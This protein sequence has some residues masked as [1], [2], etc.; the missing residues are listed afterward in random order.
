MKL[1]F[2]IFF[3]L[4]IL[5]LIG[6]GIFLFMFDLDKYRGQITS[7]LSHALDRPVTIDKMAMKI[8]MIP[9]IKISGITVG[10]PKNSAIKEPLAKINAVELT[11]ELS[12]LLNKEVKIKDVLIHDTVLNMIL[13][14]SEAGSEKKTGKKT[15]S[16]QKASQ[17]INIPTNNPY[18]SQL[19]VDKITLD[20]ILLNYQKGNTKEQIEFQ[21]MT[22]RQLKAVSMDIQYH[23]VPA[24]LNIYT[25]LMDLIKMKNNFIFNAD[26]S[27]LD[28]MVRVSGN[29]GNLKKLENILLN[30]NFS[31]ENFTSFLTKAATALQIPLSPLQ[32]QIPNTTLSASVKGNLDQFNIQSL[33]LSLGEGIIIDLKGRLA[34]LASQAEGAL[35]GTVSVR[36][37]QFVSLI[38]L[39]PMTINWKATLKDKTARITQLVFN[40]DRSD[41][42]STF[43]IAWGDNWTVNGNVTSNYLDLTN[44]YDST[45]L[46]APTEKTAKTNGHPAPQAKAKTDLAWVKKFNSQ[47]DWNLKH[48]QLIENTEEYYGIS[49]RSILSNGQLTVNPLQIRTNAGTVNASVRIQNITDTPEIQAAFSGDNINMDK[50]KQVREYIVGSTANLT[51]NLSTKGLNK[52]E[53]LSHLSGNVEMEMTKGKIVNK[54]F[55]NLPQD[56]GLITKSKSFSYSQT[57]SESTLNCAAAKL[58]FQNGIITMD[59]SLAVETSALDIVLDGQ[60]NLPKETLSVTL[61][62][63]LPNMPQNKILNAVQLIRIT[64]PIQQPDMKLDTKKIISKGVEKGLEKGLN[65]LMEKTGLSNETATAESAETTAQSVT[66]RQPLTLCETALGH[67]LKG[68]VQIELPRQIQQMPA[69]PQAP[70]QAL[71]EKLTPQEILKKQLIKS[72]SSAVQ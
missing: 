50:I 14:E 1:L 56:I 32:I 49:G 8:S 24:H 21:N 71:P 16:A 53:M 19:Q 48:L 2:K 37:A 64:G 55:N 9:T 62:P 43:N 39:K 36:N 65:K 30:I 7:E 5:A 45:A 47:I 3:L 27:A 29:I 41:I 38:G 18:L 69:T 52:N 70:V 17:E 33:K 6:G 28:S 42:S 59:K 61:D 67:K 20:K 26:L 31:T 68:K 54:W 11:M 44:F 4:L 46:E 72:L 40:A 66:V 34:Q 58:S 51:G 57:D 12:P 10:Y 15:A 63:S 22:I 35:D 25:N 23:K 60:V 13:P